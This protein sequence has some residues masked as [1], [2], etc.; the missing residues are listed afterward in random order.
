M[1]TGARCAVPCAIAFACLTLASQ[2]P[3][4]Q[5]ASP[6]PTV[7]P[8]LATAARARIKQLDKAVKDVQDDVGRA[9]NAVVRSTDRIERD[10][11]FHE[12]EAW[13][14]VRGIYWDEQR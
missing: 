2:Q 11:Y 13:E 12:K 9:T 5:Q 14:Q 6:P 8:K 10:A 1:R 4:A 3:R 7:S